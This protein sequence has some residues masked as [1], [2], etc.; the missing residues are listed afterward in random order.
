MKNGF[1]DVKTRATCIKPSTTI[2]S[3]YSYNNR[4]PYL[5]TNIAKHIYL[6]DH[7]LINIQ[8]CIYAIYLVSDLC[9]NHTLIHFYLRGILE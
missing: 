6:K 5:R 4:T 2:K 3:M 8:A 1:V 9:L 7:M